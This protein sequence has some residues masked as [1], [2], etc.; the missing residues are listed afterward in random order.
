VVDINREEKHWLTSCCRNRRD[1]N[2]TK[3]CI[4]EEKVAGNAEKP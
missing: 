2:K 3:H 4:I 1:A